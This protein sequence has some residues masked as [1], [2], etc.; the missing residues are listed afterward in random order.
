MPAAALVAVACATLSAGCAIFGGKT[1]P[2]DYNENILS[3]VAD[4]QLNAQED[5]YQFNYPVDVTGQNIFKATLVRVANFENL[6]P[7]K[8]PAS[9]SYV[10]GLC[11]EKLGDYALA[12]ANYESCERLKDP[13]LS[14]RAA[15]RADV[16]R[17]L[18]QIL[19]STSSTGAL[20]DMVLE[21]N[22]RIEQLKE[23]HRQ[24]ST[25]SFNRLLLIEIENAQTYHA[26][27]LKNNRYLLE[28]GT[29]RTLEAMQTLIQEH[30]ASKNLPRHYLMLADFYFELAREY[31][32]LNPPETHLFEWNEFESRIVPAQN[33]YYTVEKMDG[34]PEKLEGRY[35]LQAA[36]QFAQTIRRKS[37]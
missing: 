17:R 22:R 24:L 23:L 14:A 11:Y 27:L 1:P 30:A 19:T 2:P 26:L 10:K 33:Y 29:Q 15:E 35:K 4:L 16:L 20:Q 9:V 21:S 13:I 25:T 28:N 18:N 36:L 32:A 5:I 3:I 31:A 8:Y 7:G 37:F 12:V 6:Y 34:Y